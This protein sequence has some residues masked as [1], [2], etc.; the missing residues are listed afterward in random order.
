MKL[1]LMSCALLASCAVAPSGPTPAAQPIKPS[2]IISM[3]AAEL[4]RQA[5]DL[6]PPPIP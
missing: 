5:P 2:K 1:L 6:R 3:V 4:A